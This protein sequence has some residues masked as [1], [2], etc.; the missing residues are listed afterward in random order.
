MTSFLLKLLEFMPQF[1][2]R[3]YTFLTGAGL[4]AIDF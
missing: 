1:E 3:V 4:V 2:M